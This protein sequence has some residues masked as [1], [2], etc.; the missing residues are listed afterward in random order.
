[1]VYNFIIHKSEYS[2]LSQ[3]A[4]V[5]LHC[6][7]VH[8]FFMQNCVFI[9]GRQHQQI[10]ANAR[11]GHLCLIRTSADQEESL[12]TVQRLCPYMVREQ[13]AQFLYLYLFVCQQLQ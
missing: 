9:G 3:E 8:L 13:C 1:M 12:H 6:W 2:L 7:P 4:L 11:K 10:T 5:S